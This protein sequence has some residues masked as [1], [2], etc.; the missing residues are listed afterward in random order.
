MIVSSVTGAHMA[1]LPLKT[2]EADIPLGLQKVPTRVCKHFGEV[3]YVVIEP[4]LV[5]H[6][7]E[8][9]VFPKIEHMAFFLAPATTQTLVVVW[10]ETNLEPLVSA[11]NRQKIAKLDWSAL[12]NR[13][14]HVAEKT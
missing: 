4:E 6:S 1:G 5:R 13:E 2:G 7:A 10:Y 12:V 8:W 3:R 14:P 11:E 9:F